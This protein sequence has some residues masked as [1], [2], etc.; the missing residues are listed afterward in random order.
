MSSM[1][2]RLIIWSMITS[3][4]VISFILTVSIKGFPVNVNIL[5]LLPKAQQSIKVNQATEHLEETIGDQVIFLIANKDQVIAQKAAN[6]FAKGLEK[7][8]LFKHI[9]YQVSDLSQEAWAELYYP[10]RLSL[11]TQK[12]YDLLNNNQVTTIRNDALEHLYSPIG[13]SS[14][15]LIENDP[16]YLFQKYISHIAKPSTSISL[17]NS[18]LM[19]YYQ[20][21]WYSMITVQLKASGFS[22]N[23]QSE[24]TTLIKNLESKIKTQYP[25][26]YILKTGAIF[27][28]QKGTEDAKSDISMIGLGSVIGII[29][30]ILLTFR[31]LSPLFFTLFS[32]VV[33]FISAFVITFW[34][35][36]FVYLFTL[37]FGASLIGI[38]VDYAF[39]YYSERLTGGKFWQPQA[40]LKRILPG[41]TLGLINIIL[42]YLVISLAPFPGLRQLA[43]F[44]IIG[45]TMSY[46][47]VVCAFPYLLKPKQKT[48]HPI[49]LKWSNFYLNLWYKMPLALIY[50]IFL[51]VIVIS[52]IGMMRLN[53]NDNIKQLENPPVELVK[54]EKEIKSIIGNDMGLSFIVI[55]GSTAFEV[56]QREHNVARTIKQ[57]FPNIAQPYLALSQYIPSLSY[58]KHSYQLIRTKLIEGDLDS[59]LSQLGVD[60]AKIAKIK[61]KLL[62]LP[63]DPLTVEDWLRSDASKP[64]N[65]LWIGKE[66]H[67]YISVMLLSNKVDYLKVKNLLKIYPYA[68][69][70][71]QAENIS[72]VFEKYRIRLS[73]LLVAAFTLLFILLFA[74][75]GLKKSFAY[76]MV[77][78]ASAC[79][80]LAV[81]GLLNVPLT[82]FNI[83]A[84]ILVLGI[85]VDYILFF[86]ESKSGYQSTMLA[87]MLSAI[88]TVL[89]FGLLVFSS[90]PVVHYF[91]LSVFVGILTAFLLSPVVAAMSSRVISEHKR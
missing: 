13:I 36:G 30:L 34:V 72:Q 56:I 43:L 37:V 83:L 52:V 48:Y 44:A 80:S 17:Y 8:H 9:I 63:F 23:N 59:Y 50:L 49:I 91:G 1:K 4:M 75:Y 3:V 82:L 18:Y 29:M 71:N 78:V 11:L 10:H 45:L 33:G 40:G 19:V 60:Q 2:L 62:Q 54:N 88:T 87:V 42:A 68:D 84:L 69:V 27:Y 35:Y 21:T 76:F 26:S 20:N 64:L 55:N 14:T 77:P 86:A 53:A 12:D 57:V 22:L 31:S 65:F 38:S 85:A 73:L 61:A 15:G 70:I 24:V 16:Y 58:Q 79:M 41:I 47:T 39:F 25:G 74:R 51:V 28:A 5:D 6:S 7:S 67:Q 32:A 81:L 89:S 66:G 46:L 90:T